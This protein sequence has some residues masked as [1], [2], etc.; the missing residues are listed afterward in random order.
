MHMTSQ[1][2]VQKKNNN[3]KQEIRERKKEYDHKPE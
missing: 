3:K 1:E 2:N